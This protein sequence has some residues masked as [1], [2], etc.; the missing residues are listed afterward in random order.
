MTDTTTPDTTSPETTAYAPPLAGPGTA[1]TRRAPKAAMVR[2]VEDRLR[3]QLTPFLPP[4][5]SLESIG[6]ILEM[7]AI[8][9]PELR[10]CTPSSLLLAVARGLRLGLEIGEEWHLLTFR[11]EKL[12]QQH[13]RDVYECT[14]TA[15]YKAL[16]AR[17]IASGA[18]RFL[19]PHVVRTDDVL[20]DH[21][22][23]LTPVLRHKPGP[24]RGAITHGYLVY[25]LPGGLKEVFVMTAEEIE[26][27]RAKSKQWRKGPLPAWYV[28]KTLIR[29]GTKWFPRGATQDPALEALLA[30]DE[31][32]PELE[33]APEEL[34]EANAGAGDEDVDGASDPT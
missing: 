6:Q 23:G 21:E 2:L 24:G 10:A 12:S 5:H 17:V 9:Q 11:N 31:A 33:P 14:G 1:V 7:M 15:D 20:W 19:A 32:L 30:A 22:E 29:Q 25:T 18:V 26:A 27:V 8:K 28:K 16:G 3:T 34:A 13:G 4:G